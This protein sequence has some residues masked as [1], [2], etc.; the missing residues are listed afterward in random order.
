SATAGRLGPPLPVLSRAR[1]LQQFPDGSLR[2]SR[3][4]ARGWMRPTRVQLSVESTGPLA[5]WLASG[6][7]FGAVLRSVHFSLGVPTT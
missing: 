1:V 3:L 7:H 6:R 4:S 2:G 5:G